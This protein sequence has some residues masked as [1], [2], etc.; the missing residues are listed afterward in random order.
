MAQEYCK[1]FSALTE[2]KYEEKIALSFNCDRKKGG[3]NHPLL[4]IYS[5]I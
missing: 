4:S 3:E 2:S 5:H 1:N